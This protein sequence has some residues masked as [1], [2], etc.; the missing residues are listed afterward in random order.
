MLY[1]RKRAFYMEITEHFFRL[2]VRR[3]LDEVKGDTIKE[4]HQN[5]NKWLDKDCTEEESA[6]IRDFYTFNQS[7]S[8]CSNYKIVKQVEEL[9]ARFAADLGLR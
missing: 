5:T 7:V 8:S 6:L 3:E 4:W 9:A 2:A 1:K